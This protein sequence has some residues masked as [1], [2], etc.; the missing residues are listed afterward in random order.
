MISSN[1][2]LHRYN[3]QATSLILAV[4]NKNLFILQIFIL[5]NEGELHQATEIYIKNYLAHILK[6]HRCSQR[7][8]GV[9]NNDNASTFNRLPTGK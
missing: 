5:E 1:R 3:S 6:T 7:V 9:Q 8:K 4:C 2:Y